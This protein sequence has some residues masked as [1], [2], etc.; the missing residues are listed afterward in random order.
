MIEQSSLVEA[1]KSGHIAAAALDVFEV[2]PLPAT[3]ALRELPNVIV[4]PHAVGHTMDV[5]GAVV[6]KALQL[7][8]GQFPDSCRNRE[9][10]DLRRE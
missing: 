6:E 1:L 3:N 2:E 9:V 4:R 8:R 5:H 7:L 10:A